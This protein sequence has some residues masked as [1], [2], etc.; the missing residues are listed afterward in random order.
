MWVKDGQW[1]GSNGFTKT[2]AFDSLFTVLCRLPISVNLIS[3]I[4]PN[5]PSLVLNGTEVPG[6]GK[7]GRMPSSNVRVSEMCS[8]RARVYGKN[9]LAHGRAV[10]PVTFALPIREYLTFNSPTMP[11]A[12]SRR[13]DNNNAFAAKSKPF[14]QKFSSVCICSEKS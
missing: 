11:P 12:H 6:T 1:V 13:N 3:P 2:L 9:T 4:G 5:E 14:P 7:R 8:Q 10:K